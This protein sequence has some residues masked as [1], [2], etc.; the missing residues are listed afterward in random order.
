MYP[1]NANV[2]FILPIII[3]KNILFKFQIIKKNQCRHQDSEFNAKIRSYKFIN[4]N[5]VN[6]EALKRAIVEIGPIAITINTNM[7][8]TGSNSKFGQYKSGIFNDLN[9]CGQSGADHAVSVVGYGSE[10]GQDYF[11]IRNT[12]GRTWGEN[13]YIRIARNKRMCNVGAYAVYPIL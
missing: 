13:G 1:Y 2:S 12:W 11:I 6:D 10:N 5:Q 7:G 9:D 4:Y 3:L 8:I